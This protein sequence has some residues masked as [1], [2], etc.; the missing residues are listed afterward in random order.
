MRDFFIVV[1]VVDVVGGGG[2][3]GG[4]GGSSSFVDQ[5]PSGNAG[6]DTNK[7]KSLGT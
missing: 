7:V 1:L 6:D 3:G 2:G 5:N 4:G